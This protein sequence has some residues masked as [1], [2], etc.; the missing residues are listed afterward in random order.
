MESLYADSNLKPRCTESSFP[1]VVLFQFAPV[2]GGVP[3]E[4]CA[5][6]IASF[7]K[8]RKHEGVATTRTSGNRSPTYMFLQLELLS[9]FE[10]RECLLPVMCFLLRRKR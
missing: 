10:G 9:G 8:C 1:V 7:L 5:W 6:T 4:K 2:S 3:I